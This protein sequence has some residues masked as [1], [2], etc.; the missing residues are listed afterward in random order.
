M[1]DDI[2]RARET[3]ERLQNCEWQFAAENAERVVS[4]AVGSDE[5]WRELR[6]QSEPPPQQQQERSSDAP[7]IYKTY[8]PPAPQSQRDDVFAEGFSELQQTVLVETIALLRAEWQQDIEEKI[9]AVKAGNVEQLVRK[10][11]SPE[12]LRDELWR[13][14]PDERAAMLILSLVEQDKDALAAVLNLVGTAS[15]LGQRLAPHLRDVIAGNFRLQTARLERDRFP[16]CG[17]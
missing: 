10:K 14:K 7:L 12:T 2:R 17:D 15:V 16:A 9:G 13:L 8:E 4:G 6:E 3:L 11:M 5:R 1:N